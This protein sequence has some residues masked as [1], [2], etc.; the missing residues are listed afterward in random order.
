M[1]ARPGDLTINSTL[2]ATIAT[3]LNLGSNVTQLTSASGTGG[4]GDITVA[5]GISW[6]TNATLTL[7]AYRNIVVDANI[8][9]SGGGGVVLRADNAGTGTGVTSV[10]GLVSTSGTVSVYYNPTAA[11]RRSTPPN[12]PRR[13]RGFTA[14]NIASGATLK[15]YMLVNNVY[16]LQNMKNNLAGTYALGRDIDAGIT[17]TWNSGA[18]FEPIGGQIASAET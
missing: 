8:T 13:H 9:S 1:A 4:N 3:T 6:S 14:A 18:G 5:S 15:T 7:S 12:T 10:N 17:S 2:A 16:D 11:T